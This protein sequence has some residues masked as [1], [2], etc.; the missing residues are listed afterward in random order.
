MYSESWPASS[1]T[2]RG[3][4]YGN[5]HFRLEYSFSYSNATSPGAASSDAAIYQ[6]KEDILWPANSAALY[7]SSILGYTI[8]SIISTILTAATSTIVT[9]FVTVTTATAERAPHKRTPDVEARDAIAVPNVLTRYPPVIV[10]SACSLAVSPV[11]V[12]STTRT[13]MTTGTVPTTTTTST[14]ST[15][16]VQPALNPTN[17]Q[18]QVRRSDGST[19]FAYSDL[20]YGIYNHARSSIWGP[21]HKQAP[22]T[23]LDL[24]NSSP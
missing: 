2:N 12:T 10:T 18:I 8:P 13:T 24:V 3:Q 4:D 16:T 11:T 9:T 22:S 17:A 6:A 15:T 1:A 14:T 19:Q 20:G 21:S 7:C 23:G 5:D